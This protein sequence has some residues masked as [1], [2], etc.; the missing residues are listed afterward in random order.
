MATSDERWDCGAT[1][2]IHQPDECEEERANETVTTR[3]FGASGSGI[4][5]LSHVPLAL[6]TANWFFQRTNETN[7]STV[8][9]SRSADRKILRRE[10][11]EKEK[12]CE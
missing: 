8:T 3:P 5:P 10:K 11:W 2:S 4:K 6:P 1:K 12:H 7:S 9:K